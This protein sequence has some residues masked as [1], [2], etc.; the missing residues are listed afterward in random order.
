M[1]SY[2]TG[3]GRVKENVNEGYNRIFE[4][5]KSGK[6]D[7][8]E[9]RKQITS[10]R[11]QH[12]KDYRIAHNKKQVALSKAAAKKNLEK[13]LPNKGKDIEETLSDK[14]KDIPK[15]AGK[16]VLADAAIK[17]MNT[18]SNTAEGAAMEAGMST[19][20]STG[21]PYM[22]AGAAAMGAIQGEQRRRARN[23]QLAAEGIE[24]SAKAHAAGE[25][26][27]QAAMSQMSRAFQGYFS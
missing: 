5:L 12:D 13:S 4:D 26:H 22:A 1:T 10:H 24:A 11:L 2:L 14:G 19:L 18:D 15:E 16:K 20:A 21:N 23:T 25:R 9:Y 6:I 3:A 17:S 8:N 7:Q 27:K